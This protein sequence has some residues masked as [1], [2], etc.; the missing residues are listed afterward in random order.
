[1]KK[2][3]FLGLLMGLILPVTILAENGRN[4]DTHI[5]DNSGDSDSDSEDQNNRPEPPIPVP[6]DGQCA[7]TAVIAHENSK[8]AI[9]KTR[10]SS[11][12]SATETRRDALGVAYLLTDQAQRFIAI[13]AALDAFK[14]SQ[15]NANQIAK[16]ALKTENEAFK[17]AVVKCGANLSHDQIDNEDNSGD[18]EIGSNQGQNGFRLGLF[19]RILKHGARGEDVK[20]IQG[21]LGLNADG[22]FGPMTENKVKEWQAE[23]GLNDDGVLGEKSFGKLEVEMEL[24]N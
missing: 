22:V 20:N 18:N 12:N 1:M 7:S 24:E 2:I 21:F 6:Y 5:G 16:D 13:K 15:K 9:I 8:L 23:H 3:I 10:Q 4:I 19:K 17:I 11:L 14:L